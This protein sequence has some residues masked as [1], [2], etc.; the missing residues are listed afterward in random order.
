M[1]YCMLTLQNIIKYDY[2]FIKGHFILVFK[3]NQYNTNIKST[4]FNKKTMVSWKNFLEK[5]IDDFR[6]KRI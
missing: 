2:Y 3:D 6:N 5:V 4:L 1:K